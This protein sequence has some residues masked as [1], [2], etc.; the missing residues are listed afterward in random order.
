MMTKLSCALSF[1]DV[2]DLLAERGV[3]VS[4]ETVRRWDVSNASTCIHVSG[5]RC[6]F[7]DLDSCEPTNWPAKDWMR[8]HVSDA[9]RLVIISGAFRKA[10][11]ALNAIK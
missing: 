3:A 10:I 2:E 4:Y 5:R 11:R 1:R 6:R 9:S 8:D 7:R